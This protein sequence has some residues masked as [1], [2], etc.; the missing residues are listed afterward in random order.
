MV[1]GV[2]VYVC[3]SAGKKS[4]D[5]VTQKESWSLHFSPNMKH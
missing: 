1:A 3:V 2:C 5:E 4:E